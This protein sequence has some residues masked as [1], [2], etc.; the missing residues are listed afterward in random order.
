MKNITAVILAAGQGKR[1]KPIVTSKGLIPFLG[2]PIIKWIIDDLKS[3]GIEKFIVIVNPKEKSAYQKFLTDNQIKFV[4][5]AKPTGMADAVLSAQNQLS[6]S[7]LVVN[8]ADI[9][10]PQLFKDFFNKVKSAKPD[11]LLTGLK[12]DQYL[13]GGYFKL[14]GNQVKE[15]I[16][17]PG[18]GNEPSQYTNLVVHY[19]KNSKE[20][21]QTL[22]NTTSKADDIYEVALS[23]LLKIKKVSFFEYQGYFSQ[24]KYPHQILDVTKAFLTHRLSKKSAVHSTAKIMQGAIIKN[25]YIGKNVIV[26]NN[27][28]IRDSIVEENSVVGYNTE[29][30]RS[31]V[32]PKNFFHCNYIGDSVIEAESNLGSGARL[33]NFRFDGKEIGDTGKTKFGAV[34][35]KGAKL[36]INAS[37]MPGISIGENALIGS[38]VVLNHSVEPN[39]KVLHFHGSQK[40]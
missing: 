11:I 25:S 33:A 28:L 31:Y 38:G 4:V 39:Q 18:A 23:K 35:G 15:I 26:G 17:K 21:L 20:F 6:S 22:K 34:L 29:I 14:Q 19:F 2:Q 37:I 8:G 9:F 32:G 30:A 36:G 10:S 1:I 5:Q 27:A 12:V 16:E 13:P 24:L 40:S 3:A 7:I